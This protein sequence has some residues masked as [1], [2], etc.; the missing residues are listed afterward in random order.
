MNSNINNL[1]SELKASRDNTGTLIASRSITVS[2]AQDMIV[3]DLADATQKILWSV[4]TATVYVTY[5][6]TTPS[7]TN[8]HPLS[9]GSGA[10]W[11]RQ[12]AEDAKIFCAT[13]ARMHISELQSR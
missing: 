5:D 6:G 2:T 1:S 3:A 11:S 8:G 7:A 13:S 10:E 12:L 9:A 4:E